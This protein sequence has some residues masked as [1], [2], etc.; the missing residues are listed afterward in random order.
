MAPLTEKEQSEIAMHVTPERCYAFQQRVKQLATAVP[1]HDPNFTAS[2]AA[3]IRYGNVAW[4][5]CVTAAQTMDQITACNA[6]LLMN[7][8]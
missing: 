3:C 7:G 8:R 1:P 5:R 2:F 4:D 6:R